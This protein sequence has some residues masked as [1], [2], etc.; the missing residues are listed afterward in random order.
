MDLTVC[1]FR[2]SGPKVFCKTGVLKN[3]QN[4]QENTRARIFFFFLKKEALAQV[5]SSKFGK[6]FKNNFY[7]QQLWWLLL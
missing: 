6:I 5:F 7:T 1:K 4:S 3:P 2:S